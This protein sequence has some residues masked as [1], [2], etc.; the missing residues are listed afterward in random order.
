MVAVVAVVAAVVAAVMVF[1]NGATALV[2][3]S[4]VDLAVAVSG[5]VGKV[6][7]FDSVGFYFAGRF[8][9]VDGVV[10]YKVF[11]VCDFPEAIYQEEEEWELCW[12][13]QMPALSWG[14]W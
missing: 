8:D 1:A 2:A 12:A 11:D 14:F 9:L 6:E 4:S 7:N 13:L 10:N 3:R 5:H